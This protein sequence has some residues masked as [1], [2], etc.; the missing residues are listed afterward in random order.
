V[1]GEIAE[2]DLAGILDSMLDLDDTRQ[3]PATEVLVVSAVMSEQTVNIF[4]EREQDR[5]FDRS[6]LH[7]EEFGM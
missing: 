5:R 7:M 4:D 2:V 1:S 3:R 6:C